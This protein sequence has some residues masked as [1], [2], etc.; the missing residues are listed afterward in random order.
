[1]EPIGID[2]HSKKGW[3]ILHRCSS[4]GKKV[5]NKTAPD[6]ALE[7]LTSERTGHAQGKRDAF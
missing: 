6:D 3:M 2:H 5:R 7:L 4:C 1:M